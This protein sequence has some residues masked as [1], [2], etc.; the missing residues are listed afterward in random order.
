MSNVFWRG[1]AALRVNGDRNSVDPVSWALFRFSNVGESAS[2]PDISNRD[3][4]DYRGRFI[5]LALPGSFGL[6]RTPH[7]IHYAAAPAPNERLQSQAGRA[8]NEGAVSGET[9]PTDIFF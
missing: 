5:E 4:H 1:T 6:V 7:P 3:A 9:V 2:M 8:T